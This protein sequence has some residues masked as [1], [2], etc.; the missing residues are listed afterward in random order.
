MVYTVHYLQYVVD[1]LGGYLKLSF[2]FKKSLPK[3]KIKILEETSTK[4]K[5]N[6]LAAS[7]DKIKTWE[8]NLTNM[9]AGP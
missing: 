8:T 2:T 3:I 6:K 7:H 5:R 4:L 1:T 9:G